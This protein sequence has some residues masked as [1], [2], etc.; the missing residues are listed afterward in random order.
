MIKVAE[1]HPLVIGKG[2]PLEVCDGD[3]TVARIYPDG[4]V[5]TAQGVNL[6]KMASTIWNCVDPLSSAVLFFPDDNGQNPLVAIS[7]TGQITYRKGYT[8]DTIART[9]W[10]II[11]QAA[12]WC[13]RM[14]PLVPEDTH[15]GA[16][17]PEGVRGEPT[18][19]M[20]ARLMPPVSRVNR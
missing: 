1:V 15:R 12:P 9:V 17:A 3:K 14:P 19:F 4:V 8:P 5:E 20:D 10:A 6:L 7:R 2:G 18:L 11:A 13:P 16:P